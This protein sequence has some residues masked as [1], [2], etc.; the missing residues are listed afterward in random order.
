MNAL[1]LLTTVIISA[2]K[3]LDHTPVT[4]TLDINL[5]LMEE[6]VRYYCG[7]SLGSVLC[8]VKVM[9]LMSVLDHSTSANK[10]VT[11]LRDRSS[12]DVRKDM[13]WTV[14]EHHVLVN[15][16]FYNSVTFV[17]LIKLSQQSPA[18][19]ALVMLTMG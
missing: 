19:L 14:K 9:I 12:V 10:C 2:P 15:V 18:L 11:T 6:D 1:V 8:F 5:L 7:Y 17:Y 3:L 4:A 13:C 16:I